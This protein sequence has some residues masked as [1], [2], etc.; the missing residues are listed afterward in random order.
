MAKASPQ[1]IRRIRNN[2]GSTEKVTNGKLQMADGHKRNSYSVDSNVTLQPKQPNWTSQP[3]SPTRRVS[4]EYQGTGVGR[5]VVGVANPRQQPQQERQSRSRRPHVYE[6]VD[7]DDDVPPVMPSLMT[8]SHTR[9]RSWVENH[10]ERLWASE[11][12][13]RSDSAEGHHRGDRVVEMTGSLWASKNREMQ[14]PRG[15]VKERRPHPRMTRL[16]R[17]AFPPPPMTVESDVLSSSFRHSSRIASLPNTHLPGV[18]GIPSSRMLIQAATGSSAHP[19]RSKRISYGMAVGA[20]PVEIPNQDIPMRDTNHTRREVDRSERFSSSDHY[21]TRMRAHS[22]EEAWQTEGYGGSRGHTHGM[23]AQQFNSLQRQVSPP[24]HPGHHYQSS[25]R[26]SESG[27]ESYGGTYLLQDT[28]REH[29]SRYSGGSHGD[30]RSGRIV[31]S[32]RAFSSDMPHQRIE[33][34]GTGPVPNRESFL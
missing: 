12:V 28:P 33:G 27:G 31:K 9:T 16:G 3:R 14:Q 22:R 2:L 30:P 1:S 17:S 20:S 23:Y 24:H 19:A 18:G 25:R 32:Q 15:G 11:D 10:N 6:D 21:T 29:Y 13:Q 4:D 7:C 8:D 5:S 34:V 26:S